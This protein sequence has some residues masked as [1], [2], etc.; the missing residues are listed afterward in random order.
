MQF[1]VL[2]S[3][4]AE[5]QGRQMDLGGPKQRR[6]LTALLTHEGNSVSADRLI[7]V[8]WGDHPPTTANKILQKYVS[9]LRKKVGDVIVTRP[10]GYAIEVGD[11]QVDARLFEALLAKARNENRLGEKFELLEQTLGLWRGDP[12]TELDHPIVASEQ[13]RLCD[14]RLS[15]VE[16]LM[17]VRLDLGEH[18]RLVGRLEGLVS[19]HPLRERLWGHLM[20]ALYRSGRQSEALRMYQRLRQMLGEELGIEPSPEIQELEDRILIQDPDLSPAT[21]STAR[22]NLRPALTSF[23]GRATNL[24]EVSE[25]LVSARLVSLIGPAGSGKTR[26]ATE[27]A[28]GL[29]EDFP[30]G[31]WFVD[32]APLTSPDQVADAIAAPLGV[33]GQAER[34]TEAVLKD[35]LPGRRFLLL[36]DNCEHLVAKV[37][38][39]VTE[40]LQVAPDLTVLATSRERLGVPGEALYEVPPLA[41]PTENESIEEFDAVHLFLER[42]S[43]ADAHFQLTPSNRSSVAEICRRLDGMPLALELAAARV[44]SIP[45]SQLTRYLD[46]RFGLLTSV[47]RTAHFRHQ[48]L[49]AAVDW[50][51]QLLDP[52]EQILFRRLSVFRGGFHLET[53]RDVCGFDP[54]SPAQVTGILPELVDRSLA[55]TDHA[56]EY[57]TRYRVLETLREY[58]RDNMDTAEGTALRNS[59]ASCF[60]DLSEQE[61]SRMRGPEQ[62]DAIQRLSVEYDNLRTALRWTSTHH[63]ETAVRLAIALADYWDAVGPRAEGHEWLERAVALSSSL[64]PELRIEARLA[65]CELFAS[66]HASFSQHYAEEALVE[67]RR[68]GD[69]LGEARALRALCWA[70]VLDEQPEEAASYGHQALPILERH[71]D[72][73]ET[74]LCLERLAEAGYRDPEQAIADLKRSVSLY[75]KAGDRNRE[76]AALRK[77]ANFM[78]QGLGDVETAP[79]YAGQ[80]IAICAE[81]GNLNNL[82][83]AKLEYGK[84]IRRSGDPNRAAEVLEEAFEQLSKSGDE[85]CSVRTLT[86]LGTAHLDRADDDAAMEA[87]RSSLRRGGS[88]DELHTS[89]EAIAGIARIFTSKGRLAEAVTLY[90]FADKLQ[91]DLKFPVSPSSRQRREKHLESLRAQ[92]GDQDF[93]HAQQ[94]AESMD[95]DQAVVFALGLSIQDESKT[96][97]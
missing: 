61:A 55:T 19:E 48:S 89:R 72:P 49:Q 83:H 25:L 73:W 2:G 80:A 4:E 62:S 65:A 26:L 37:G 8:L 6:L 13:T 74:G 10:G 90:G 32:L 22:T 77:L 97:P 14:L 21:P 16:D 5:K 94:E 82:A 38:I 63:P 12:Y 67:T 81:L 79:K 7:D 28:R 20:L 84:I 46:E 95:L 41:Y 35:Y 96:S 44:R 17:Q 58:G 45:P 57:Q 52:A 60:L 93:E 23:I 42:A 56:T 75:R 87:F 29:V 34:S 71:G 66:A 53:A 92:I 43:A 33:G 50:S 1:R 47:L 88:L 27:V 86:A 15:A 78:S 40:L 9:H 76:S 36:V 85:R 11:D 91:R 30:D 31:V 3:L 64:T 24:R 68:I 69:E 39:L 59:H 51:Y 54:L 70:L 18:D